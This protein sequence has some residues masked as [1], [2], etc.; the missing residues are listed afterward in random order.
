MI[1]TPSPS[2]SSQTSEREPRRASLGVAVAFGL[3]CQVLVIVWVVYSEIPAKVFISSWS[4]CM[5]GIFLLAVALLLARRAG[6]RLRRLL[7]DQR[8]MRKRSKP[9]CGCE[10]RRP[11][12][13][14]W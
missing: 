1:E 14:A 13:I 5:P 11:G 8:Q 2:S 4:I 10:G 3:V 9:H 6:V 7:P 12:G